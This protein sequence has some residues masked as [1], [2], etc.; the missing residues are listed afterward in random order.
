MSRW[1]VSLLPVFLL[2]VITLINPGYMHVL[3][4]S[5]GGRIALVF[6]TLLVISGSLVIKRIINIKI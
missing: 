3:Y 6:A 1:I 5:A 2:V 4:A